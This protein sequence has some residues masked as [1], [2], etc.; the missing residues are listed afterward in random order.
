MEVVTAS[1]TQAFTRSIYVICVANKSIAL[2]NEISW[3]GAYVI[4]G[5]DTT[6]GLYKPYCLNYILS[7]RT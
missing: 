6:G 2:N 3:V 4:F 5:T 1:F 7:N